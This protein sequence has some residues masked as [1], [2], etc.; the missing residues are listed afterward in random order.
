M[1]VRRGEALLCLA[2]ILLDALVLAGLLAERRFPRTHDGY[3]L[4]LFQYY[5]LNGAVTAG[6]IPQWVPFT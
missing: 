4:L 6:E 2:V 1:L 5:V 3:E